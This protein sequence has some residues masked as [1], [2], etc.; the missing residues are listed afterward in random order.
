MITQR[1]VWVNLFVYA[2]NADCP[3]HVRAFEYLIGCAGRD[4]V[5][6]CEL[7]LV[8]LYILLRNPAVVSAPLA[9]AEGAP[10]RQWRDMAQELYDIKLSITSPQT[11]RK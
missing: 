1:H 10:L 11:G 4:D 2:Q 7:V 6:I 5:A 3:E 9:A 8:E